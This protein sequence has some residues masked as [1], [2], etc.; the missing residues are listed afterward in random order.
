[1]TAPTMTQVMR[2][3]N[4]SAVFWLSRA[5]ESSRAIRLCTCASNG[6]NAVP[7]VVV[8][9]GSALRAEAATTSSPRS[10]DHWRVNNTIFAHS[11][12]PSEA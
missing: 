5:S 9:V 3:L 10:V 8:R 6:P 7:N 1:M 2:W 11:A 12:E 4:D